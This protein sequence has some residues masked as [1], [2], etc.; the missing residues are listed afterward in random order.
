[1]ILSHIQNEVAIS[2]ATTGNNT[3]ASWIRRPSDRS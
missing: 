1:M 2:L 3:H